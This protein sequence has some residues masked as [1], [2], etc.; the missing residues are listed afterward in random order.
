MSEKAGR[1]MKTSVLFKRF[2]PY[3]SKY[4]K[5][6]ALDL[7]CAAL[8]TVCDLV[9]PLIVRNITT[10]ASNDLVDLASVVDVEFVLTQNRNGGGILKGKFH[11]CRVGF[12]R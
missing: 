8:T 3:Y 5:E 4:K 12:D 10:L 7:F 6:M 9:L 1:Q 11:R 2:L